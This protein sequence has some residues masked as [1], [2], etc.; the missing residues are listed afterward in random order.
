M[1]KTRNFEQ[2]NCIKKLNIF[3]R[4]FS[5]LIYLLLLARQELFFMATVRKNETCVK[6][7]LKREIKDVCV[8]NMQS[9]KTN[10]PH[11]GQTKTILHQEGRNINICL[12]DCGVFTSITLKPVVA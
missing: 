12:N 4:E 11:L 1:Q 2:K 9:V 3:V 8:D 7:A 6:V 10:G 5:V